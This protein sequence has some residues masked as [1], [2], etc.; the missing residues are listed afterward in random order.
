M[1]QLP[2]RS[3]SFNVRGMSMR[4]PEPLLGRSDRSSDYLC[5]PQQH[6]QQ[7]TVKQ[8]LVAIGLATF[9]MIIV[10]ALSRTTTHSPVVSS[11]MRRRSST[12][13]QQK[14]QME[15]NRRSE[16]A[17]QELLQSLQLEM[18]EHTAQLEQMVQ[19]RTASDDALL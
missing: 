14:Q 1:K 15:A 18:D 4:P 2:G 3:K 6:Q 16:L 10:V 13:Q 7:R 5:Q 17:E 9:L 8:R 11:M 19:G 12:S